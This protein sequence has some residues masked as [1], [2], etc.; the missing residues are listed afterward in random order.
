MKNIKISSVCY[1]QVQGRNVDHFLN[2]ILGFIDYKKAS[3]ISVFPRIHDVEKKE[4]VISDDTYEEIRN[5][6]NQM[7]IIDDVVETLIWAY[8]FIGS[9]L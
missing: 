5:N 8:W 3:A 1:E 9:N 7:E 4:V 6:F 2:E